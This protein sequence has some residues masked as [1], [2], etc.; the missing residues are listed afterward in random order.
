MVRRESYD[1]ILIGRRHVFR[2]APHGGL[3]LQLCDK[4]RNRR[5]LGGALLHVPKFRFQKGLHLF[6]IKSIRLCPL[7]FSPKRRNVAGV[8]KTFSAYKKTDDRERTKLAENSEIEKYVEKLMGHTEIVRGHLK[9]DQVW[10]REIC[11]EAGL[12]HGS[13]PH[14]VSW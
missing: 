12:Y 11:Y 4:L 9:K 10:R 13:T 5:Y 1:G 14:C 6:K 2:L 3:L 7:S 8:E